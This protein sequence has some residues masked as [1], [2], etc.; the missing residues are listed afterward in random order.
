MKASHVCCG[1]CWGACASCATCLR[2]TNERKSDGFR[3]AE[4]LAASL[5]IAGFALLAVI[6][7]VW[8][9]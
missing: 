2:L 4:L 7:G 1:R 6:V 8:V 3:P 9:G 5:T